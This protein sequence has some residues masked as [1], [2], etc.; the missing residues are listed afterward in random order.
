MEEIL[1][2]HLDTARLWLKEHKIRYILIRDL[3]IVDY[4]EC[5]QG[6]CDYLIGEKNGFVVYA[7]PNRKKLAFKIYKS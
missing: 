2:W 3:H 7:E 6:Q 5:K 1:Y 4:E